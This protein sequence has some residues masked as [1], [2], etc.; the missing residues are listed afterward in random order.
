VLLAQISDLDIE[1]L[2][3]AGRPWEAAAAGKLLPGL[4]RLHGYGS[5]VVNVA[6]VRGIDFDDDEEEEEEEEEEGI[7]FLSVTANTALR[8]CV[9]GEGEPPVELLLAAI[10]CAGS[11]LW[12]GG[13][14]PCGGDACSQLRRT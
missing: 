9:T 13:W 6:A 12:R 1:L 7:S 5:V 4:A 3:G 10:A 8:G 2:D 11:G 14:N